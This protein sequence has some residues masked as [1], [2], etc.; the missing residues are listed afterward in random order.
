VVRHQSRDIRLVI[1]YQY[2]GAHSVRFASGNSIRGG[3]IRGRTGLLL[4]R[5]IM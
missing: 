1:H 3:G 2:V 4:G 5:F